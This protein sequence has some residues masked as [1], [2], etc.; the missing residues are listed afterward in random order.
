ML[1]SLAILGPALRIIGFVL[2]NTYKLCFGWLDKRIARQNE[3]RFAEDI[4]RYLAF[5][6]LERERRS[7]QMKE[8]LS[9][10][11]FDGAY[12][13]VAVGNLRLLFVRGRGDFGS[14]S[15]LL[16][17]RTIG[18]NFGWSPTE[19]ADGRISTRPSMLHSGNIRTDSPISIGTAAGS[20]IKRAF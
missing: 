15:L 18:R 1:N 17:L 12:V 19:S 8:L 14:T 3:Q 13:T 4:R 16:L 5:L 2:G 7:F 6:F 10:P 20:V 11:G 9:P